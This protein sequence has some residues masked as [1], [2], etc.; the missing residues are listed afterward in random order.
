M[1]FLTIHFVMIQMKKIEKKMP[2]NEN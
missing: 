2:W 1:I